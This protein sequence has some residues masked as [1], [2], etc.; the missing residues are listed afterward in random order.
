M[1]SIHGHLDQCSQKIS[2]C[3][4]TVVECGVRAIGA[5]NQTTKNETCQM[6]LWQ[7]DMSDT[8]QIYLQNYG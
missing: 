7:S 5:Q 2:V 4:C 1:L 8:Q 6:L 3:A